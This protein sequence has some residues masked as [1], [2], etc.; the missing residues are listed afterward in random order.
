[1]EIKQK[2]NAPG[3]LEETQ[4]EDGFFILKFQNETHDNQRVIRDIDSS[5]IQFHFCI[6]GA[7]QFNFNNGSYTIPL[8]E[9]NS[10]LLYNPQR[11]LPMNLEMDKD[12]WLITVLI[13]I[14]K[15]HSLFSKEA[16]YIP[17]L[18]QGNRDKKY[19]TDASI[20]PAMA[21]VLNQIM[22][23]S[24]HPSI[25]LLYCKG[26][27]YELLSLYFNRPEDADTEQCPFLVDEENVLKIRKAKQIVIARMAE[28][29]TLQEL[30]NEI[31]LPL[32][33]LKDGF[34]QIYGEPVYAF[35]FDYKME[36]ARQLLASGSHNVNEV[37]LKVG[38]STASHFIAA[39][40][41]KFGTTPKKY[42]MSLT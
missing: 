32:R 12:S 37:G 19:Y 24:L 5:F 1:M 34:K 11:D 38:Y 13:S 2:N 39:F 28:P 22:N 33:K 18:G 31:G 10:L 42:V 26:K 41:K 27:A 29:P 40:K 35:L 25:K 14:K 21:V 3:V 20:S 30:A 23:Y 8:V 15:F 17:F 6:K 9:E 16:D 4:I 7:V 36:V